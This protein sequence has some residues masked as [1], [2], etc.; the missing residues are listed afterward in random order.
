MML[1]DRLST[2]SRRALLRKRKRFGHPSNYT[3]QRRLL[4][5][6]SIETGLTPEQVLIQ[7]RKERA[8]LSQY[9]R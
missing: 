1:F 7:L 3:P 2:C 6:I 4:N 9:L 5:R 8:L